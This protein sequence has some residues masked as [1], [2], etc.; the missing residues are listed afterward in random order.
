MIVIY[1]EK[2]S[3]AKA[4]AAAMNAGKRIAH[5]KEPTIGHYEFTFN[6]LP[7]VLCHGVGHLC[8][9]ADA[10]SYGE[11]YTKWDLNIYPCIPE[12]YE[13]I[14][15]DKTKA[16]FDYV[17][18]FFQKADLI[19]NATDPDREGELIFAYIY[20]AMN[21]T[22]PWKRA[23]IEDLTPQ[24]IRYAFCHL[25]D[26]SE[27]LNIQ[28]AGK[29][30][31]IADWVC[32]INLTIAATKKLSSKDML[33]VGRVQTPVLAMVVEREKKIVNHIKTP[34]WKL[35]ADFTTENGKFTA[36]Y[37]KGQFDDENKA[38]EILAECTGKGTVL[39][40]SVKKKSVGQPLLFNATLLQATAGKKL[41]WDLKKTVAV[42]QELY[43]HKFMSYPRTSSEHLTVAMQPEVTA[44]LRKL[45]QLPEYAEYAIPEDQWQGY[46][47]RHFD[48]SKVDSH[49]AIIP[50]M[51]VPKDLSELSNDEKQLYDLLVK[52]L[53]R[54]VYPKAEL[55][56]TTV[57]L[58]VNG[59]KFKATGSII[60][61]NGWYAVDAMPDKKATLPPINEGESYPGKY[62]LKQGFTEPPKRY[63]EPDLITAMETAGKNIE[64]EEARSL[65]KL[66]NK[67]LG[68]AATR[69]AIVNSLFSR[70]YLAKKGKSIYPT[71]KGIFIIDTLPVDELKSAELT[72]LWE[73]RLH[74]I[75]IG[76]E[77]YNSFV[78]DIEKTVRD[79]YQKI[80]DSMS[81]KYSD[82]TDNQ[83]CP[84]CGARVI[85][86]KFGYFCSGKKDNGCKFFVPS[87]ICGKSIS[88][89]QARRLIEKGKTTLIKGLKSKSGKE[90]D[91]YLVVDKKQGKIV[92]E[93]P[94][95]NKAKH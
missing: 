14:V 83:V 92:F 84:F 8:Q 11:Q 72:G 28:K 63:T 78:S 51:N 35:L 9:L 71:E 39:S 74:E 75:S 7:A 10:K 32:G 5:P 73:K 19:I 40:K 87:E 89:V 46:T 57:I 86:G 82:K 66:E 22:K 24:K 13:V 62:S 33:S 85:K 45:F 30:R 93:F 59:N 4:I 37:E 61:N 64:D 53:I 16:C 12:K 42:M 65:M 1:A 25:R 31:S 94:P 50:T 15:K 52:S 6:G 77:D 69:A 79:W 60:T 76:N 90:F 56:D 48:D 80:T 47:K 34:F 49:P 29:A 18:G 95:Q 68:T 55:E 38:K 26:S 81:T 36:E 58:N 91:A 54:I 17:K 23:W 70:N 20:E 41:G 21:C 2:A 43:E 67:G 44:T 3:L 88:D 27:V